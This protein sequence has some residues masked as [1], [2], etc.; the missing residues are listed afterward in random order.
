MISPL[1]TG[2]LARWSARH[3]WIVIAVWVVLLGV[4]AYA[5]TGLGDAL[6]AEDMD[7]TNT[8][9]SVRGSQ[10]IEQ[11]LRGPEPSVETVIVRVDVGHRRRP[12]IQ[13][14]RYS[15]VEGD[16]SAMKATVAGVGDYYAAA[17]LDERAA[18]AMVSADRHTVLIPVTLTPKGAADNALGAAFVAPWRARPRPVSPC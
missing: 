15:K 9:E 2:L 3:P 10:L 8:P 12:G 4:A 1:S 11:R 7:F 5:A 13:G 18:A 16:L 6:T 17:A 14:G